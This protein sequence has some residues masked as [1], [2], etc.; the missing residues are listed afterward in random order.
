MEQ[1]ERRTGWN[2]SIVCH[3]AL[4]KQLRKNYDTF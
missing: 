3:L 1:M 4:R 2:G